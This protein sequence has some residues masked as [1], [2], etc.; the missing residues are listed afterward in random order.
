[1][2]VVCVLIAPPPH[3]LSYAGKGG[4]GAYGATFAVGRL[5]WTADIPVD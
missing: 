3:N 2:V 5:H 4:G 1:M